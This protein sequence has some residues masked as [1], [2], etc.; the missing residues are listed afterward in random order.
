M[1]YDVS[2]GQGSC[3]VIGGDTSFAAGATVTVEAIVPAGK[4]LDGWTATPAGA[5]AEFTPVAGN[6]LR[7]TFVMPAMAVEVTALFVD[8]PQVV[9]VAT[10]EAPLPTTYVPGGTVTFICN[11]E[12][13]AAPTALGWESVIPAVWSYVS[14][15]S[16]AMIKPAAGDQ[17]TLGWA[18]I[19]VPAS[20]VTFSCTLQVPAAAAGQVVISSKALADGA[21]YPA[22]DL[23]L[24]AILYDIN[25]TPWYPVYDLGNSEHGVHQVKVYCWN[26]LVAG[27]AVRGAQVKPVDYLNAGCP[28][29]L[30][31]VDY[32]FEVD[33]WNSDVLC[34]APEVVTP[35]YQ[36]P[37]TGTVIAGEPD[38]DNVVPLEIDL[39]MASKYL[40]TIKKGAEVYFPA[41]EFVFAAA[42][43]EGMILPSTVRPMEFFTAG[44]YD[45]AVLAINPM[46]EAAQAAARQI[47]IGQSVAPSDGWPTDGFTPMEG[48]NFLLGGATTP[49]LFSWPAIVQ[50]EAYDQLVYDS[51][52]ATPSDLVDCHATVCPVSRW[53]LDL[54]GRL[55]H[56]GR[57]V[58]QSH[59]QCRRPFRRLRGVVDSG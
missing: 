42:N 54:P 59:R 4:V 30:S 5:S 48:Q 9:I 38:A 58:P 33:E 25:P 8:E 19:D 17:G 29:L 3:S 18:W 37:E 41:T 43:E 13:N 31:G 46:G 49:V 7:D 2:L 15:T 6:P 52:V 55:S 21:E 36:L 32:V 28:G 44:T 50:V 22:N 39:P 51:N 10:H 45:V 14:D 1:T 57:V 27:M 24:D 56:S 20:P 12:F 34:Q 53:H 26:E 47:V 16:N 40:L 23:S 35:E 11:V